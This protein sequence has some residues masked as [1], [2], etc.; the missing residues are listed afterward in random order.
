MSY[1]YGSARKEF[2]HR[3][4]SP[5]S[6]AAI[7]HY[8]PSVIADQ[9]H[10]SRGERYTFIPTIQV[11]EGLRKEGFEPYEVRQTKCRD[12]GKRDFTRHMVRMRHRDLIG[13]QSEVPEIILLN[14]HD[15]SSSYQLLAGYFRFVCSN[16]LIAGSVCND[17]RVRHS[18]DVVGSV[19]EGSYQVVQDLELLDSRKEEYKRIQLLDHEQELFASAAVS[20]RWGEDKAPINPRQLLTPQRSAD[21]GS[22][23]FTIYNRVQENLINGGLRGRSTTG[24]RTRTRA[25]GGVNENVR[26]NKALWT[27]TERL[28]EIKQAA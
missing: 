1:R 15:G 8:A 26:L 3:S 22:D 14:S 2:T 5:L 17:V 19:I 28:A 13:T 7:A 12:E 20:L 27:L 4:D 16:G 23:L 10:E 9:A 24:R 21:Y 11:I 6:N 18:G 25:V